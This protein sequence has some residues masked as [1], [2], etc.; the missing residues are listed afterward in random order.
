MLKVIGKESPRMFISYII[1]TLYIIIPFFKF[2]Y[3]V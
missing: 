2:I 1:N 3:N